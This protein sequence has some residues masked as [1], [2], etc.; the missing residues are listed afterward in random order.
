MKKIIQFTNPYEGLY[1]KNDLLSVNKL[2][3]YL[4]LSKGTTEE[5]LQIY[6]FPAI[7]KNGRIYAIKPE[8]DKWRKQ[9]INKYDGLRKG[10]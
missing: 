1:N 5:I 6:G 4:G 10:A 9:N 8:V 7:Y 3:E 2:Q